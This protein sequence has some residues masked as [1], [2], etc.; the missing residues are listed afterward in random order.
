[1]KIA[2]VMLF[3]VLGIAPLSARADTTI[4][5][6]V[7]MISPIPSQHIVYVLMSTQTV[8]D[9]GGCPSPYY[10]GS[11]DDPGFKSFVYP[12]I[13]AA[14]ATKERIKVYVSGCLGGYPQIS[15]VEYTDRAEP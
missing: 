5:A 6:E 11:T 3:A 10:V 7:H 13:V 8:L 9:G 4:T 15:Q 12:L 2:V 1:M 14:K